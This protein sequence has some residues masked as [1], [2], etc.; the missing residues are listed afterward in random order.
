ME[1][2]KFKTNIK[3]GGCVAKVKPY[4]D[5]LKE[6]KSWNVDLASADRLLTVEGEINAGLITGA[7]AEAGYSA[8]KIQ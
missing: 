6:V 2:L 3:C 4:L 7:L 1:Q 5:N 8:E